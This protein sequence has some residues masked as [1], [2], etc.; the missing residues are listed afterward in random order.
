MTT[1]SWRESIL[2]SYYVEHYQQLDRLHEACY[3][4]IQL[5][6]RRPAILQ[7]RTW[8]SA[9][10]WKRLLHAS[11]ISS[12]NFVSSPKVVVISSESPRSFDSD[13][14]LWPLVHLTNVVSRAVDRRV[15]RHQ[16]WASALTKGA[17]DGPVPE[18]TLVKSQAAELGSQHTSIVV[19]TFTW[20][21]FAHSTATIVEYTIYRYNLFH[22]LLMLPIHHVS[23]WR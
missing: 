21:S 12:N 3:T 15:Q 19:S 16:Q 20:L 4:Y 14:V 10:R 11:T 7:D 22:D 9:K 1:V 18:P 23:R 2:Q 17:S 5:Y 13:E 6:S 8:P